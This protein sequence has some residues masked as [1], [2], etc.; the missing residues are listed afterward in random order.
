MASPMQA[1]RI[2]IAEDPTTRGTGE[3]KMGRVPETTVDSPAKP[4]KDLPG[5]TSPAA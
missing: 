2:V 1:I 5:V 3:R 4:A